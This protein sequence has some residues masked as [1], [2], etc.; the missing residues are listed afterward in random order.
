MY[1]KQYNPPSQIVR[2]FKIKNFGN[3]PVKFERMSIEQSGCIGY[4]FEIRNCQAFSL[5][6]N[7]YHILEIAFSLDFSQTNTEKSL[8]LTTKK[9]IMHFK[10]L[11][12]LPILSNLEFGGIKTP[13]SADFLQEYKLLEG[14]SFI[15][16]CFLTITVFQMM[17]YKGRIR[18]K[19]RG[20]WKLV[21]ANEVFELRDQNSVFSFENDIYE[22][23]KLRQAVKQTGNYTHNLLMEATQTLQENIRQ[24][25]YFE[26]RPLVV[27]QG[28]QGKQ[29]FEGKSQGSIVCGE[30][31]EKKTGKNKKEESH[32]GK[33]SKGQ[34]A[35]KKTAVKKENPTAKTKKTKKEEPQKVVVE[36]KVVP[37]PLPKN[38]EH[39]KSPTKEV[40]ELEKPQ[41]ASKIIENTYQTPKDLES[42]KN[43]CDI[44]EEKSSI[45]EEKE[46]KDKSEKKIDSPVFNP[47]F[48]PVFEQD[49][50]K[51][52][53]TDKESVIENEKVREPQE[54]STLKL[55]EN[56]EVLQNSDK[57]K[58]NIGIIGGKK[59]KPM[60]ESDD[61]SSNQDLD[62]PSKGL[63]QYYDPFS[64]YSGPPNRNEN[65]WHYSLF[66]TGL[67]TRKS[68]P[69][70]LGLF[71]TNRENKY[72]LFSNEFYSK[73]SEEEEEGA[74]DEKQHTSYEE[75]SDSSEFSERSFLQ[76]R[77]NK[78]TNELEPKYNPSGSSSNKP[79]SEG[80]NRYNRT[81]NFPQ[82]NNPF[83][84][85]QLLNLKEKTES[86][87]W[88]EGGSFGNTYE[89]LAGSVGGKST[90][91]GFLFNFNE[92]NEDF[93]MGNMLFRQ[94]SE[95]LSRKPPPG[96][97]PNK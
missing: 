74:E 29:E 44:I 86:E 42:P 67:N 45:K 16:L 5:S 20:E 65:V 22:L 97:K 75:K 47:S 30:E 73:K 9:E 1:L 90:T 71:T 3:L 55:I 61:V 95:G 14:V 36:N 46:E 26:E 81:F 32:K 77:L 59:K 85:S 89:N 80:N 24:K 12:D 31:K 83:S 79:E 52:F 4:G 69:P 15:T 88:R 87:S 19:A 39:E 93:N 27:E 11:V 48:E 62:H 66:P 57:F 56:A 21:E 60:E 18:R 94:N 96:F 64:K 37:T 13:N 33:K 50:E 84:L 51:V 63:Q 58:S 82:S 7:G 49:N 72:S 17:K 34:E 53:E 92:S 43:S 41:H 25:E 23:R 6:P 78:Q 68:N 40:H 70:G 2:Y 35:N 54:E 38:E 91:P 28:D 8:Y 10:L 76:N